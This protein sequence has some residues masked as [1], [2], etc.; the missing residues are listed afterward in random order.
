MGMI[1]AVGVSQVFN[2]DW[3]S[4]G[5]PPTITY[6]KTLLP[7]T[8]MVIF[9]P[10][11]EVQKRMFDKLVKTKELTLIYEAPKAVNR[12]PGHGTDPRNTLVIFSKGY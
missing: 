9:A 6:N 2:T 12:R 1:R 7:G 8:Y 4:W 11:Q 10:A 3:R 5:E